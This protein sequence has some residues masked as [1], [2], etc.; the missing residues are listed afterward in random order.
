[1]ISLS[2]TLRFQKFT[3]DFK[4]V[5]EPLQQEI[6]PNFLIQVYPNTYNHLK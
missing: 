6:I 4:G 3:L 2:K 5:N 1:M